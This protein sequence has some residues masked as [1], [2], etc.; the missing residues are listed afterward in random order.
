MA[1]T[2]DEGPTL[3][4]PQAQWQQ[5]G[6]SALAIMLERVGLELAQT[7]QGYRTV[8]VKTATVAVAPRQGRWWRRM[9]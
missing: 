2:L 7:P 4:A 3:L 9:R 8:K 5:G 6:A 1:R